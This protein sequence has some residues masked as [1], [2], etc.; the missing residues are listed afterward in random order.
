MGK[1][2][3]YQ[4]GVTPGRLLADLVFKGGRTCLIFP[5]GKS[6]WHFSRIPTLLVLVLY[7]SVSLH[8]I[9]SGFQD[10]WPCRM[11]TA[12]K[13]HSWTARRSSLLVPGLNVDSQED[14]RTSDRFLSTPAPIASAFKFP[15]PPQ[16]LHARLDATRQWPRTVGL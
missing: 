16:H 14:T 10:W 6:A 15:H 12:L 1:K 4:A 9:S 11:S 13:P 2:H 5:E 8:C 7:G 3:Q